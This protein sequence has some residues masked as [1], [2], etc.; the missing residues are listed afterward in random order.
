MTENVKPMTAPSKRGEEVDVLIIGAGP[1]G[2]VAAKH[3]SAAGMTVVCL[4]QG[5]WP[6]ADKFPGRRPEYELVSQKQW[7]PNP[8]VRDLP[9]DYPV[10]TESS[11]INPLMFAG[12]GGSTT[13]YAGHWTPFLPSDF[14]VRT[15]DGIADDWPFSYADLLP[16]LEEVEHEVGVSGLPGNPMY[17]PQK[18]FPTPPLP[19]GKVGKKAAQGLDKLGWHWWPGT[20]AIPSVPYNGLNACVR[21]GTCMTGCPE[22]AKST[23]NITY[24]P[25]AIK[26][27]ARLITGAR[28][29]KIET[30]AQGLATGA[31]YID[32][33]GRER[34]QKARTVIICAN[35]IGTPRLL[36]LSKS[37]RFPDGLANSSGLV[38]KRLMMHPFSAV[39]GVFNDPLDSWQGPFGQMIDSYQ[40]YESD[41]K[42]GFKRGAKWGVMPGGGPLGATSFV[43]TKVF[44]DSAGKVEDAWGQNLH[45]LVER[46]FNHMMVYGIIGEDLPEESNQV[47]LDPKMTDSDGIPAPKLIY[48]VS[49]NSDKMLKFHVDC[50]LEAVNASG[51]IETQVVHQMPDT[52]WHLLGT[53]LMGNDPKKSVVNQWGQTHDV[54]NLYIFDGSTFPTSAGLNPTA[55]IMSVALRQT[56]HMIS[57]RRNVR[58]A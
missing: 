27:G 30:N 40:F 17:P 31:I 28:V 21:R 22:G 58:A 43:G 10:N 47:V 3:L 38:G 37:D 4:E 51:A 36:L 7:H 39:M 45:K 53:C 13:L 52:G 12:V 8:N 11:D 15:L 1:S 55:T 16:F 46:R 57:E 9:R 34:L 48:K 41:E 14:K 24:W 44:G 23:S 29:R 5:N 54:P 2:S 56:K 42:R 6:D 19:I 26:N 49:E 20:N 18:A 33:N 50:C 32:E 35:G 25:H